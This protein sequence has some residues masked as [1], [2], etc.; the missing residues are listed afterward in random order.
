M[1]KLTITI[2][3]TALL[4]LSAF[5]NPVDVK[6]AQK[7]ATTF[8]NNNGAK[9][10]QLTDLS[11][12]AGFPNLYIFS[13]E[14]S[15]VIISRDDCAKPILGYSLSD[16]F[17]VED[18][19]ENLRWW[20]Q[21][22]SDQIQ[23]AI[24]FNLDS[25]SSVKLEWQDLKDGKSYRDDPVVVVNPL[26]STKWNQGSP[27][28]NLCP[29]NSVTGCVATAMAQVMKYH[30][31]PSHG[32]GSHSYIPVSNPGYG[33]LTADFN[34]TTYDWE[35]MTNTYGGSSTP[36]QRLAVATLMYHCGVSVD[37]KYRPNSTSGTNSAFVANALKYYFGYS[38]DVHNANRS[39]YSDSEWI[40]LLKADLD[41][42]RPILYY[43]SG[44]G[45]GHA[46]VCDG[47]RDDD[48]FHFNWGWGGSCDA[49]Y[50]VDN[51]NPGPGG[52]G[53]GTHGIYNDNQGAILGAHPSECTAEAPTELTKTQNGLDVT[54]NWKA[55]NGAVSYN[56]YSYNC[57][58][59]N[60]T[61][62]SFTTTTPY[63]TN[64][65]YVRSAD[66][67]GEL[68]LSSNAVEVTV[69]YQIPTVGDLEATH[70]DNSVSLSWTASQ[71][72]YP[73]TP[74]ST[75]DY[76]TQILTDYSMPWRNSTVYWGHRHLSE[77]LTNYDGMK[78]Y[79]VDF[80]ANNAGTYEVCIY[81]GSTASGDDVTPET[82]V[83][84][85][86]IDIVTTGWHSIEL[87]I[88][89]VIDKTK[90]LWVFI[91][92]P[93]TI[94]ELRS[95]ICTAEGSYG[96][97][98]S[99]NPLSI[100]YNNISDYAFLIKAYLTD[101][102]Y[103]YNIYDGETKLNTE[104]I[105][106]T[107]YTHENP[108][109]DATHH[110][111]VTTNY[112]GGESAVSNKASLALGTASLEALELGDN[113]KMTVT[114]N[115]TLTISGTL[116]ND[117][118]ENL[119]LENGAQLFHNGSDVY[120]TVKKDIAAYTTEKNGW[121]FIASP[122]STQLETATIDGLIPD[123]N[124]TTFDLYKYNEPNHKWYNY[125]PGNENAQPGFAIE[126]KTGYLYACSENTT[127]SFAGKLQSQTSITIND[128]S[129]SATELKGFNL[130]GNPLPFNAYVSK[131]YY[132][133]NDER[134]N[135]VAVTSNSETV[136]PC[137]GIIVE[138]TEEN[139]SVTFSQT[140]M[141]WSNRGQLQI[142]V[143][144]NKMDRDGTSVGTM[145]V[146]NAIICLNETDPLQKFVFN[147]YYAKLYI[148]QDDED[149]AIA[150]ANN[151]KEM[152]LNFKP[153][154]NGT[155][156]LTVQSES[157]EMSYLLLID[158]MTGTHIN[159][160]TTPS[161]TFEAKTD[162]Y[163]SRFKLLFAAANEETAEDESF[164]FIINGQFQSIIGQGLLQVIDLNG[165][166]LRSAEEVDCIGLNGLSA[167]VYVLR[168][169]AANNVKTQK[170]VI[171]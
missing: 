153:N 159:L 44:S 79:S 12:A 36:D 164:G 121:N 135:I 80:H 34:S 76:G 68:S 81:E 88:P 32:I 71:W 42:Q 3:L 30:N 162:D 97:Y 128:L 95:Y 43:G 148:P 163:E 61:S 139:R 59:G 119:I 60:T 25:D 98:Y 127:L 137:T 93:Q 138:A 108:A 100:M 10:A 117:N 86:A 69:D 161:Y 149:Y 169:I 123:N 105:T 48:Y 89:H 114:E 130:V 51:L 166:I 126:P 122:I 73:E 38:S 11:K 104:N 15:F 14:S 70:C 102:T 124:A 134:T 136:A 78:L 35:N 50:V 16:K 147:E 18:M 26:I 111:T 67:N 58:I 65:Y 21:G 9:T 8:L 64:Y 22:Y 160:L 141:Q 103:T 99:I 54:F 92:N 112:Y 49:Y 28:N 146:D 120:A 40:D 87:S 154:Q 5:A 77:N 158:N 167:G 168:F 74:T 41:L 4:T 52:I 142:A 17:S 27:Y 155:F 157:V 72:C 156:T 7:V 66:S 125:K 24:D 1:K 13:T 75:L 110:Y 56:I 37:M 133:M 106:S 47:Y 116:N 33:T 63:G 145:K 109:T 19:P 140:Q 20:L 131:S 62:T 39:D 94:N 113:D 55:A 46:F 107:T 165:R 23:D 57:Y 151:R 132:K 53:S 82:Q 96:M 85:Q 150:C 129:Y 45:G 6:T 31:H 84:T 83:Y 91:H 144:E 2:A 101:G 118:P 152:P 171:E 29:P 90:D 115:S 170:I 143:A